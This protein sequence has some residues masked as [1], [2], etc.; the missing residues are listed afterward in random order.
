[1][2]KNI[3]NFKFKNKIYKAEKLETQ[4]DL[5]SEK[6]DTVSAMVLSQKNLPNEIK[7]GKIISIKN[8]IFLANEIEKE[9]V[10]NAKKKNKINNLSLF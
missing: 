10:K 3:I 5:F 8:G 7:A 1:M 9:I 6:N 4:I 2:K